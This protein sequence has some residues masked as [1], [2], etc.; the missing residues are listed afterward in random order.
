[1]LVG[2]TIVPSQRIVAPAM[3]LRRERTLSAPGQVFVQVGQAVQPSDV[4]A[5]G[6]GKPS[7]QIIDVA[8]ALDLGPG[9][10]RDAIRVEV[11]EDA[12]SD[13]T[14]LAE[15]RKYLFRRMR[16]LAPADGRVVHIDRGGRILFQAQGEDEILRAGLQGRVVDVMPRF[17]SVIE[18]TGALV[19]GI[20]GNGVR[21]V[22]IL[23]LL[24]SIPGEPLSADTFHAGLRGAIVVAGRMRGAAV[25]EAGA[26]AQI[27]GLVVGSLPP[28]LFALAREQSYA[29]FVTDG[30]SQESMAQPI[31]E[32][33]QQNDGR[34][35]IVDARFNAGRGRQIPELL[36]HRTGDTMPTLEEETPLRQ[37]D[38]VRAIAPPH[39]GRV[40]IVK[41]VDAGRHRLE[42]GLE[43]PG[44]LVTFPGGDEQFVPHTNVERLAG[45]IQP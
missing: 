45:Y 34:E 14:I 21:A 2:D 3:R 35:A 42:S 1:M 22:G 41:T 15:R 17:G 6:A 4:I 36:I 26:T 37:G 18:V 25:F 29:V 12:I 24:T 40:G 44:C 23:R 33:L 11:G 13:E 7:F 8:E 20:W 39:L 16:V 43:L 38:V 10:A 31:F 19:Q 9:A 28:D 30:V 5:R 32:I 27:R